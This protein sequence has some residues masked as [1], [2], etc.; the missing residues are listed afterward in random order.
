MSHPGK[1]KHN[2]IAQSHF[3]SRPQNS[4]KPKH[5][6]SQSGET[7]T[8]HPSIN[9]LKRYIRNAKRVLSKTDLPADARIVQERALAGYEGELAE[10]SRRR[11]RSEMIRRYH[12]VRFLGAHKFS[13]LWLG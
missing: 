9:D 11:Q 1:R 13:I 5:S 3:S 6:Q 12:F 2:A 4:K 7:T 10:E 8:D